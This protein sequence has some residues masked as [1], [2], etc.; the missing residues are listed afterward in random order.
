M[1]TGAREQVRGCPW[2][3]GQRL[4]GLQ[5][6]L[7]STD[8]AQLTLPGYQH[9][10][11][12][13]RAYSQRR[14]G[15][16]AAGCAPGGPRTA[17]APVPTGTSLET[18]EWHEAW[19]SH[20]LSSPF[21]VGF[22]SPLA[23]FLLAVQRWRVQ[24]PEKLR[25]CWGLSKASLLG[26]GKITTSRNSPRMSRPHPAACLSPGLTFLSGELCRIQAA[27]GA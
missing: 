27:T 15:Q 19:A 14:P 2:L 3:R 26:E 10:G 13:G 6:G 12:A 22:R 5:P 23:P 8:Q 24:G 18:E 7:L 1:G 9:C 25:Q 16:P 4:C 17:P 20:A 11:M 21:T